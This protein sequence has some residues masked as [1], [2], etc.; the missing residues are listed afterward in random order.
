MRAL[1]L[2]I[3]VVLM[4]VSAAPSSGQGKDEIVFE[5]GKLIKVT[6]TKVFVD[7]KKMDKG[8][9][10]KQSQLYPSGVALYARRPRRESEGPGCRP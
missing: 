7:L 3:A 2:G 9:S 10:G 5:E 8:K 4:M 6:D 1:F